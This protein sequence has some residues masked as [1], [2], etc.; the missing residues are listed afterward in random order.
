MSLQA[1]PASFRP[2]QMA[3]RHL[4]SQ[5]SVQLSQ[6]KLL[7]RRSTKVIVLDRG[8]GRAVPIAKRLQKFGVQRAFVVQG[9]FK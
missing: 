6:L 7:R 8:D 2:A 9:G 5:R 3:M 4:C 1:L